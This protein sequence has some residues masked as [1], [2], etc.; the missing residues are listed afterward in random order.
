MSTAGRRGGALAALALPLCLAAPG[1]ARA[2]LG[3]LV[4]RAERYV[5]IDAAPGELRVVVSLMLGPSEA[6][7]ALEPADTDGD[8][9]LSRAEADAYLAGWG[10]ELEREVRIELD[11]A[12]AEGVIWRDG[13]LEP[14]G[15]IA[16][17]P[18]TVERIAHV[19]LPGG[20]H[21]VRVRDAMDVARFERTDVVFQARDGATLSSAGLGTS[22]RDLEASL[23]FG[24]D[25][26]PAGGRVFTA[27]LATP[28]EPASVWA[29]LATVV[30]G[31][32]LAV[33]AGAFLRRRRASSA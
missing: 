21:V 3:H 33:L 29:L 22:P 18:V 16:A 1:A 7:S 25:F 10:A 13:V 23:S 2:H 24:S 20:E 8:G 15:P 6:R 27:T 26:A 14:V 4:L 32:T 12:P 28:E 5:K 30:G 19:P 11:D 17:Q 9:S 31:A